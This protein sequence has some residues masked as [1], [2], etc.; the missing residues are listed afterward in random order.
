MENTLGTQV[1]PQF[2]NNV[3]EITIDDKDG[4]M[5]TGSHIGLLK[6]DDAVGNYILNHPIPGGG[7]T[8]IAG[9]Y[10]FDNT[11][12]IKINISSFAN[13]LTWILGYMNFHDEVVKEKGYDFCEVNLIEVGINRD[14]Y[15]SN[16]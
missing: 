3:V 5:L 13:F 16:N 15:F 4:H 10:N 6:Y 14:K 12:V 11:K 7:S 9:E 8:C 2:A 1:L